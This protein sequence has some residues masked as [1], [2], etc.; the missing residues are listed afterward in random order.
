[1]T[2][3]VYYSVLSAIAFALYYYDKSAARRGNRRIR[4]RTLHLFA[5]LGGWPGALAGRRLLRHK[6]RKQP[7][8][9]IFWLTVIGNIALLGC[10]LHSSAT[11]S[12][13]KQFPLHF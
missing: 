10:L 7:F 4:E 2:L 6:T 3:S 1:M 11:G 8:R 5:L 12:L 13:A 9:S